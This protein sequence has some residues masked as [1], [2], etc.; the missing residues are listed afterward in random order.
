MRDKQAIA[1]ET[2]F[3]PWRGTRL[4]DPA[5]PVDPPLPPQVGDPWCPLTVR[6]RL[7]RIDWVL[8]RDPRVGLTGRPDPEQIPSA[9][10]ETVRE[11]FKDLPGVPMR[12]AVPAGHQDVVNQT[13]ADLLRYRFDDEA[14]AVIFAIAQRLSGDVL[15]KKLRCSDT[16][17]RKL[18][19]R[20]L[21]RLT[22]E[23]NAQ[24]WRPDAY[25]IERAKKLIHRNIK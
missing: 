18:M 17:A 20:A 11:L 3:G 7:H 9:M 25:D 22:L 2:E 19:K 1:V 4:V 12:I 10:P 8:R 24:P 15:G 6:A 23:W 13:L 5:L 14:K 16:Q 21:D